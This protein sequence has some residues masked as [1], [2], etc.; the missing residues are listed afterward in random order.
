VTVEVLSVADGLEVGLEV[1]VVKALPVRAL[2]VARQKEIAA[3]DPLAV[4]EPFRVAPDELMELA[5]LVVTDGALA[6]I[7][8]F[9]VP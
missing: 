7:K 1:Q 2:E 3:L 9:T 8:F 5:A 6:G 4:T